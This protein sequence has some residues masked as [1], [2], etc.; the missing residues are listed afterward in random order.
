MQG[1]DSLQAAIDAAVRDE[2]AL[3]L[4]QKAYDKFQEVS[5][6][7]RQP[8]RPA[9]WLPVGSLQRRLFIAVELGAAAAAAATCVAVSLL[10]NCWPRR[11]ASWC[12]QPQLGCPA[13]NSPCHRQPV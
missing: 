1:W 10:S 8:A 7:G 4:F 13:L 11:H 6:S 5:A 9:S 12:A 3:P 2:K